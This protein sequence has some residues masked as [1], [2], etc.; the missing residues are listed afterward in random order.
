MKPKFT[1]GPWRVATYRTIN[2]GDIP[3][4]FGPPKNEFPV[5]A[6]V[7]PRARAKAI[8][9]L[10]AAAPGLYDVV[11]EAKDVLKY[12]SEYDLPIGLKQRIDAALAKVR[13]CE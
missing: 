8:A 13:G 11:Q 3:I 5:I 10:I 2:T 4:L 1:P 12:I 9:D 7:W 6:S